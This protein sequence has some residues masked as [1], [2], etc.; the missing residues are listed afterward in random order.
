MHSVPLLI[1]GGGIAGAS[2][3]C[4]LAERGAGAGVGLVDVDL[5][6]KYSSSELNG[7]GVRCT[8]AEPVNVRVSLAST[9]YYIQHAKKFDFRQRGYL[10]MYDEE[11]WDEAHQFLPVV[12]NFGLPVEQLTQSQLKEK[13]PIL[14]DVSD[15]AG[16]TFTPFDG[17]LSPHRLRMHYLDRAQQKGVQILDRWQVVAIEGAAGEFLVRMQRVKPRRIRKALESPTEST[18]PQDPADELIVRAERIV[19]AAGPW[20]PR[21]AKLYGRTLPVTALPRQVYLIRHEQV[22]LEPLPFFLD[23]PQDIYFRHFERDRENYTLVSWSDPE[24][25]EGIHFAHH[26]LAYYNDK[27]KP[28]LV[29]RIAQ[30]EEGEVT[31]GWVGHYELSPDKGA[32]VGPVPERDGIFNYSGLSAHGVMQSRGLAEALAHFLLHNSWPPELNL[33]ELTEARFSRTSTLRERMYV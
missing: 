16:A 24:E 11:L 20:A 9:H 8:F 33:D 32:I 15:L 2:L 19:N 13:F 27:V 30:L 7:G 12:R 29:K 14:S 23:Y 1:I 17:R 5:W 22:N 6:G 26:G 10:W 18:A 4:S 3:A 28:F 25:K 31:G 21:L